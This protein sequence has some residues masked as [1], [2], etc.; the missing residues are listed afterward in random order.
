[1]IDRRGSGADCKSAVHR[2]RVV[3]LHLAAPNYSRMAEW[4][5]AA[6]WKGVGRSEPASREFKSPSYCQFGSLA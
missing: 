5:K 4:L 1:M 2:T 6:S 3:R